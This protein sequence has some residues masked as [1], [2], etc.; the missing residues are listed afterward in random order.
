MTT[1]IINTRISEVT[2]YANQALVTRR[3]TVALTGEEKELIIAG[4]PLTIQ[5]DSVRVRGAGKLAVRLLGV[6]TETIFATEAFAEKI[7]LLSRQIRQFEL[8]KRSIQDQLEAAQLQRNFVQGL[9]EKSLE[10]FSGLLAPAQINLD[11]IGELL[12]FL[13]QQYGEY[14]NAIALR[15]RQVRDLDKQLEILRQQLKQIQLSPCKESYTSHSVIVAI[16]PAGAGDFELEVS[17]LVSRAGWTPLYDLRT[18]SNSDRMNISLLAEI[19]QKTG[20]DWTGVKLTLSTAKP[21]SN[22]L[23]P[24]LEPWYVSGRKNNQLPQFVSQVDDDFAELEALLADENDTTKKQDFLSAQKVVGQG[25]KSDTEVTLRLDRDSDISSNGATHK[26]IIFSSDYPCRIEY[27]SVPRLITFA[28]LE[29]TVT[30]NSNGVTLLPGKGN[31]FRNNTLVGTTQLENIAP[32]QQFKLNLGIDESLK[33]DRDLVEREVQLIGNYR[34]TTYTYRLAIAN[35]RAQKTTLRLIEQLPV[36]REEQIKVH[37]LSTRPEIHLG[38]MGQLEWLITLPR[39]S[40]RQRKKEIYY[41]FAIEHP[42]EITV[43]SLDI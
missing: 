10:G 23:P 39:Q 35:L 21:T 33:I 22:T 43:M 40:K 26:V 34:R 20:E 6:R 25:Y 36:S 4:L 28:Y 3:G 7:S 27:V 8:Q 9:S 13:G 18:S 41:Q 16:G 11:E 30:N 31:I 1:Q 29:A 37:L 19:R 5:T 38:E 42:A 12:K 2:I 15:E 14:A 32:S 24:K 17:Y